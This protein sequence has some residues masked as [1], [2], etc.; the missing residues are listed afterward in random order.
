MKNPVLVLLGL[1]LLSGLTGGC[2]STSDAK[3]PPAGATAR[4]LPPGVPPAPPTVYS[5]PIDGTDV[6]GS[7]DALVTLVAFIDYQCPFTQRAH[8][9]LEALRAEY[10]DQLRMA[11][12]HHPQAVHPLARSAS[13]A[14]LAAGLQG[15]F[16]EYHALLLGSARTLEETDFQ[17][18]ALE[19]GLDADRFL[20]DMASPRLVARVQ[21]DETLAARLRATG[22]PVFFINGRMLSGAR[23]ALHFQALI[24]EELT[25]ARTAVAAG[26]TPAALYASLVRTGTKLEPLTAPRA[27]RPE[28]EQ[29]PDKEVVIFKVPLDGAPARGNPEALVTLV[30]FTDYQCPYCQRAN[31]TVE[32]L[33][34]EYGDQL[35]VVMKHNP[36]V[37][38]PRAQPAARAAIAAG[39]Q[40]KFWEF[41]DK[42]FANVKA[43]QDEDLE[44]YATELELDLDRW[45]ADRDSPESVERIGKDQALA[46]RLQATGTPTFFI[47]G[48]RL[49]GAQPLE[50]FKALIDEE[51][52]KAQARV[53][54]GTPAEDV[55]DAILADGTTPP[56]KPPPPPEPAE[57]EVRTVVLGNAPVKGPKNAPITL[58]AYSDFEC[59]FCA[60]AVPT[61][62]GLEEKYKGKLRIAFKHQPLPFHTHARLAAI[63]SLAAHEQGKFWPYHDVLFAHQRELDPA[64]L[65]RHAQKL[66]LDMK[67]FKAALGSKKL[68]AQVDADIA[69]AKALG[70][71]GTPTFFINGRI[72]VGA[73]PLEAFQ[74][75]I[76]EE[77][78]KA[79][80]AKK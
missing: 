77:L 34:E 80:A 44:R 11:I 79:P 56:P 4:A 2:A 15:K 32:Q 45:E 40:G 60:R 50:A 5:V 58:V 52:V 64:S 78:K 9:T 13:L 74:R 14:A 46:N 49:V 8:E 12:R 62:Q 75:V 68:A 51:F 25:K 67:R 1:V 27:P 41:H 76:D 69:E 47:N 71:S 37:I 61:L 28:P 39:A 42:L 6:R 24:D 43:L 38:H 35:R 48:R 36:L 3:A 7:P 30:E 59:P 26:I 22:T 17:K 55:Y 65:E 20:R 63:A 73:Q 18:F 21:R 53:D 23:P 19:L 10:G 72:L 54:S 33:R 70:V 29:A 57:P 16:W 66:G 31:V